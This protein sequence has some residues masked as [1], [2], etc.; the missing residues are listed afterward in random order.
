VT[1]RFFNFLVDHSIR[2]VANFVS[3]VVA[4]YRFTPDSNVDLMSSS[5]LDNFALFF[6]VLVD[7]QIRL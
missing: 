4:I 7:K 6:V 2:F 5:T 1:F 3:F